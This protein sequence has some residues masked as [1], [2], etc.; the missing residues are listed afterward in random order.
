[1]HCPRE[2]LPDSFE[3]RGEE[4]IY[5][6][7]LIIMKCLTLLYLFGSIIKDTTY[8]LYIFFL[9]SLE[10]QNFCL[11]LFM[12]SWIQDFFCNYIHHAL[13]MTSIFV[14]PWIP[15]NFMCMFFLLFIW[16]NVSSPNTKLQW[17]FFHCLK[18]IISSISFFYGKI[19]ALMMMS[20]LFNN[21]N[22]YFF[23]VAVLEVSRSVNY[24]YQSLNRWSILNMN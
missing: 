9:F 7:Y 12:N 17:T 21:I 24:Y 10:F 23:F 3:V 11:Q 22:L 2:F 20:I 19:M 8:L 14:L 15:N 5:N 6:N 4:K 13:P 1:M 16:Y 18:S